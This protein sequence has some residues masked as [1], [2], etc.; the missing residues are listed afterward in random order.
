MK[1]IALCWLGMMISALAA[2]PVVKLE[3]GDAIQLTVRGIPPGEQGGINGPYTLDDRG[4]V[5]L[6]L[7]SAPL[8]AQGMSVSEFARAAE[9]AYR[10]AGIY[11]AP[12]IEVVAKAQI[13]AEGAKISVGGHVARDGRYPFQKGMTVLQAIDGAGGRN[14]FASRNI[15]LY[16]KGK[17]VCL[18]FLELSHKNIVLEPGDSLQVEQRPAIMDR[19]KG[20]PEAV[21]PYL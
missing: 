20:R 9:R 10:D 7:L 13:E 4:A 19:W 5:R 21:A 11:T 16:R 14:E 17:R 18:D 15:V 1:R 3:P 8:R 12:A 2:L 6:P